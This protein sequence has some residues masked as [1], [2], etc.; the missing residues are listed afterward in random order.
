MFSLHRRRLGGLVEKM[1]PQWEDRLWAKLPEKLQNS[2]VN[3]RNLK[4]ESFYTKLKNYQSILTPY[5]SIESKFEPSRKFRKPSVDWRR[6]LA[7]GTLHI[8]KPFEGPGQTD[9]TPNN[10]FERLEKETPFT[11]EEWT[12]RKEFRN[13][14]AV[15]LG[16]GILGLMGTYHILRN[17]TTVW[18]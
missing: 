12:R 2:L 14:H 7:R 11:S 5:K 4:I 13:W 17:E 6:Q 10:T 8:G 18:S 15:K 1:F 16:Y 3:Q 9:Y